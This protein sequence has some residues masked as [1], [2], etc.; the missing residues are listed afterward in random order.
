M[1]RQGDVLIEAVEAIPPNLPRRPDLVLAR[2]ERT[3]H[4]HRIAERR[5]AQMFLGRTGTYIRVLAEEAKLVH[6]EHGPITL[7]RGC[8]RFWLQREYGSQDVVD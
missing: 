5:S 8:Y 1:W 7:K 2:G 4:C 6:D 3:G